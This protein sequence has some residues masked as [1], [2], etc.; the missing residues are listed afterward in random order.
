VTT[1]HKTL[2]EQIK[3]YLPPYLT[4]EQ[5]RQLYEELSSFPE[6]FPYKPNFYLNLSKVE[7]SMLQGDGL[8]GFVVIDFFNLQKKE[9]A[10]VVI[11]NSCDIDPQ[12]KRN[13]PVNILF[14]PIIR[15]SSH[16]KLL[17]KNGISEE[18]I[19]DNVNSIRKQRITNIFYL[20]EIKGGMEEGIILLDNIH[21]H[22]LADFINKKTSRLFTL[23]QFG[24]YLFLI[25][26]SI[27][28][29]R[30]QENVQRF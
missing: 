14:S 26:L 23:S 13:L 18:K 16:I 24:F 11:S 30:F 9:A 19:E 4:P 20:P 8:K 12:N 27:H 25:K 1:S 2:F 7:G 3:Q 10:G 5:S 22:P 17:K 28:F 29:T 21:R 15:L 6:Q